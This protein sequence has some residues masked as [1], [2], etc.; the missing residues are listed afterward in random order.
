MSRIITAAAAGALLA[1]LIPGASQAADGPARLQAGPVEVRPSVTFSAIYDD[2]VFKV[3]DS[4]SFSV[5]PVEDIYFTLNPQLNLRLPFGTNSHASAGYAWQGVKYTG[6]FDGNIDTTI[7]DTF[8][9]HEVFGE[10]SLRLNNGFG[11][12]LRDD[13][14][15]KNLFVTA[16]ELTFDEQADLRPIGLVHNEFKPTLVYNLED[17]NLQFDAGYILSSERFSAQTYTY[18]DKNI[19]APR[20]RISYRFFPKTAAFV[21]GEGYF[22]RYLDSEA[23]STIQKNDA[24]GWKAWLGAQG[25]VTS[26]M[27]AILALGWGRLDYEN[28]AARAS[29]WLGKLEFNEKF[30]ERTRLTVGGARELY[31]SYS[32]SYYVSNRGYAEFWHAFTPI[33]AA[34]VGG[35]VFSNRYSEPYA[36][37]DWGF[38][39]SVKG[40]F[41][42]LSEDWLKVNLG[43]NREQRESDFDWFS[44]ET[45]QVFLEVEAML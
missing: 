7:W 37:T 23:A 6:G 28:S 25:A 33:V 13:L 30:S 14:V 32:T 2:N 27:T 4:G 24:D 34:A 5:D 18:L 21:E 22:V 36:R 15:R 42:P 3:N 44:Y 35:N 31:D 10:F 9:N 8:N 12:G 29:T 40:E 39:A 19:H 20:G 45:N 17:S 16:T 11:I 1:A 38:L 43:Y 26:R 41:R